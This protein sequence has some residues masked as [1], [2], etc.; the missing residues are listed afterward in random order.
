MSD[1]I[2]RKALLD[3][4]IVWLNVDD[5]NW[6]ER[7]ILNCVINEIISSPAVDEWISVKDRLPET[8]DNVIVCNENGR[9]YSAWYYYGDNWLYAFTAETVAHKITHWMPLPEPPKGE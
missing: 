2:S 4:F 8:V 5:Y 7:N 9:V 3:K 1:L 6:G